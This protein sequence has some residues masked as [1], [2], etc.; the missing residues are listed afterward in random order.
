MV[1]GANVGTIVIDD[2]GVGNQAFDDNF[3][4]GDDPAT[5]FPANFP[6]LDG[7]EPVVVGPLSG[8]LQ[9]K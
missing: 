9:T 3:E 4:L 2:F 7:G 1:A 8:T 5:Q 6:A